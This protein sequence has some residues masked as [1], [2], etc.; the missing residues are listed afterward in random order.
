MFRP[1]PPEDEQ[2]QQHLERENS[3][4][5]A[6]AEE[7]GEE[8]PVETVPLAGN[9]LPEWLAELYQKPD[10]L[11]GDAAAAAGEEEHQQKG[12]SLLTD[13]AV[14]D[15]IEKAKQQDNRPSDSNE[16][17][18]SGGSNFGTMPLLEVKEEEDNEE[19]NVCQEGVEEEP[20]DCIEPLRL[21]LS[22]LS[23]QRMKHHQIK[24]KGGKS[25]LRSFMDRH[26]HRNGQLRLEVSKPRERVEAEVAA[27]LAELQQHD[28]KREETLQQQQQPSIKAVTAVIKQEDINGGLHLPKIPTFMEMLEKIK[29][30]TTTTGQQQVQLLQEQYI[31][32]RLLSGE[33]TKQG[34]EPSQFSYLLESENQDDDGRRVGGNT[35]ISKQQQL[36]IEN[37]PCAPF[38]SPL[39]HQ[40]PPPSTT[41]TK[42]TPG[43]NS[44]RKNTTAPPPNT[45]PTTTTTTSP[46]VTNNTMST[47]RQL[48]AYLPPKLL[49]Q[50]ICAIGG[51]ESIFQWQVDCL[52]TERGEVL[53]GR[54]NLL[55]CAPTGS[56][57]TLIGDI[58]MMRH[59]DVDRRKCLLV[60]PYVALCK[61]KADRL[62]KLL[63][64]TQREVVRAFGSYHTGGIDLPQAGV[65]VATPENANGIVNKYLEGPLPLAAHISCVVIDEI[66]MV[67]EAGRGAT[68]ELLISK[69]MFASRQQQQQQQ[70]VEEEEDDEEEDDDE[71]S[72]KGRKSIGTTATA[73]TATTVTET[74]NIN[75]NS[76]SDHPPRSETYI[77]FIGMSATLANPDLAGQWLNAK[78]FRTDFRPVQLSHYMVMRRSGE[79]L[80]ESLQV[81]RN[82]THASPKKEE[83][84]SVKDPSFIHKLVE[85]TVS[86]G[87]GVIVFC[88]TKNNCRDGATKL[89]KE[90]FIQ[91]QQ[92]RNRNRFQGF[93]FGS[94]AGGVGP[95]SVTQEE[96]DNDSSRAGIVKALKEHKTPTAEALV[97]LV[98]QGIAFHNSNLNSMEREYIERGFR[99]GAIQ[100]LFATNTLAAGV[101]LPARRIIFKDHWIGTSKNLLSK[102]TYMQMAGRAG[103]TGM[104]TVGEAYLL[105]TFESSSEQH[106]KQLLSIA[107]SNCKLTSTLGNDQLIFAK[108]LLEGI[109]TGTATKD[110]DIMALLKT[111]LLC[112][113]MEWKDLVAQ[114]QATFKLLHNETLQKESGLKSGVSLIQ[115]N[116]ATKEFRA[117]KH[118]RAMVECGLPL[119]QTFQIYDQLTRAKNSL[120]T[121]TNLQIA[122]MAVPELEE[123][124][125]FRLPQWSALVG[126][127]KNLI[128]VDQRAL[129]FHGYKNFRAEVQYRRGPNQIYKRVAMA[130]IVR[131]LIA[132][133]PSGGEEL[134]TEEAVRKEWKLE[135]AK[136]QELIQATARTAG[137]VAIFAERIGSVGIA[138]ELN[139]FRKSI[140]SGVNS[141]VV[142]L[143]DIK[144]VNPVLARVLYNKNIQEVVQV[145]KLTEEELAKI[146]R[147]KTNYR[148]NDDKTKKD[149][150]LRKAHDIIKEARKLLGGGVVVMEE[151]GGKKK[152][153][154]DDGGGKEERH[155][156]RRKSEDFCRTNNGNGG[157]GAAALPPSAT[158]TNISSAAMIVPPS[159][160]H[161]AAPVPNNDLEHAMEEEEEAIED[162][163]Q[164]KYATHL[165]EYDRELMDVIDEQQ[166]FLK[167]PRT[168][169]DDDNSKSAGITT[170]TTTGALDKNNNT[171][172]EDNSKGKSPMKII[173]SPVTDLMEKDGDDDDGLDLYRNDN[174]NNDDNGGGDCGGYED[175]DIGAHWACPVCTYINVESHLQCFVCHS[176]KP[177]IQRQQ[178]QSL[179]SLEEGMDL[180]AA[181]MT[182]P[183]MA[184]PSNHHQQ[185]QQQQNQG[186]M[187][188]VQRALDGLK[189]IT[190]EIEAA[191]GG[192]SL[193]EVGPRCLETIQPL[194][195]ALLKNKVG[196][197]GVEFDIVVKKSSNAGNPNAWP[198]APAKKRKHAKKQQEK[199]DW[200]DNDDNDIVQKIKEDESKGRSS[201]EAPC[202]RLKGVA[203]SWQNAAAIYV[204][205][206]SDDSLA[207]SSRDVYLKDLAAL[208]SNPSWQVVFYGLKQR[209]GI[210][211]ELFAYANNS[212]NNNNK[213][214]LELIPGLQD[215]RITAW[216]WEPDRTE[217]Q[218]ATT[219]GNQYGRDKGGTGLG[220]EFG[221]KAAL[222]G[223]F[224][225]QTA[226]EAVGCLDP[227]GAGSRNNSLARMGL[228]RVAQ[229]AMIRAAVARTMQCMVV[230][231]LYQKDALKSLDAVN[232]IE[233]PLVPVIYDM[234]AEGIA[235]DIKILKSIQ[236]MILRRM[237]ELQSGLIKYSKGKYNGDQRSAASFLFD[238]PNAG[239]LGLPLPPGTTKT[240]KNN[241][242]TGKHVL[243]CMRDMHTKEYLHPAIPMIIQYRKLKNANS[244]IV[245]LIG[246]ATQ[247]GRHVVLPHNIGGG[248]TGTGC[249]RV[250][251]RILQT[252]TG[253]GRLAMDDPNFQNVTNPFIIPVRPFEKRGNDGTGNEINAAAATTITTAG[254][255][256]MED[257][258]SHMKYECNIR[259][260]FVASRPDTVI[261]GADYRQIELR[262]MAHFSRDEE[263]CKLLR[264]TDHDPFVMLAHFWKKVPID[265]VKPQHR[266]QAKELCYAVFYGLGDGALADKLQITIDEAMQIRID[267]LQTYRGISSFL[268]HVKV[269]CR[270]N[271]YIEMMGGRRRPIREAK[272]ADMNIAAKGERM[273]GNSVMQGSAADLI[274][275]AMSNIVKRCATEI[276]DTTT[277][278]NTTTSSSSA[279]RM[280]LQIHDELLFEVEEKHLKQ[281]LRIIKECM[282]GAKKLLVPIPVRMS[283]GRSWGELKEVG[284]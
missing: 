213:D 27:V 15:E 133:V 2:Q 100:V 178:Q 54:R 192:V 237:K 135:N 70:E 181:M 34:G 69:I 240:A 122:L 136:L 82:L 256:V 263:I 49:P 76:G 182:N 175:G 104:D 206:P 204:P 271:G 53:D 108:L 176:E 116:D 228:G 164:H 201:I 152:K 39:H 88:G 137:K 191:V 19:A 275:I 173:P 205:V 77:Q 7:E 96:E 105:T 186:H 233:I 74:T 115:W 183:D 61:E 4:T 35:I 5:V 168:G 243:E 130:F 73:T 6:I 30:K 138:A 211:R 26:R 235:I 127:C 172:K 52:N 12:T 128:E 66:H 229:C 31:A 23:R 124:I 64:P 90:I 169:E 194:T 46:L 226:A 283:V 92:R 25:T 17:G 95:S 24:S 146:I 45:K 278:N 162:Q 230:C 166:P 241:I 8:P 107:S 257:D 221:P 277:D 132:E 1:S 187:G 11:P 227:T 84:R 111:T 177:A 78:M 94:D 144:G 156:K 101:N 245:S 28:G 184:G 117:T 48:K 85:E 121:Q 114:T 93:D 174:N 91:E 171:C 251:G 129:T 150:A 252:G 20:L 21:K 112:H 22:D 269:L 142:P 188:A 276:I 189:P 242:S 282:E 244:E 179:A 154:R 148:H 9:A 218:D 40:H 29:P 207:S 248:T 141:D 239:G 197:I 126:R 134:D 272:S 63:Q 280:L 18:I 180:V 281:V 160:V 140:L 273:A 249:F 89:G 264:Q 67:S 159:A 51:N 59:L 14:H 145:A 71:H 200:L 98:P 270:T 58:I 106:C 170:T 44:V 259:R 72:K 125:P 158:T 231:M 68:L 199:D 220:N 43:M 79:V 131:D 55:V 157:Q 50:F 267:F 208:L 232:T 118:G 10:P 261:V 268:D 236:P 109:A 219:I 139:Q 103:R 56:G 99:C 217:V 185:Q 253:T 190:T 234:E 155:K 254:L 80:N 83:Q 222:A 250:S 13:A 167:L 120:N 153:K 143:C 60:L 163:H 223:L 16:D 196:I 266:A 195:E 123:S 210:L 42:K 215:A 247:K 216:A 119:S 212:S 41:N 62:E 161:V 65:I 102:D 214:I 36:N 198:E 38:P 165:G 262:L 193:A 274:K 265:K 32:P 202:S 110:A 57:K 33:C 151:E 279:C 81:V 47:A 3:P 87:H 97:S 75:N 246:H 203:I 260:A 86:D 37:T 238:G 255:E 258:P 113:N 149:D 147:K 284:V 224:G 225:P 209:V